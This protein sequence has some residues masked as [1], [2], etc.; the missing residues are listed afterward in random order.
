MVKSGLCRERERILRA[1]LQWGRGK[2]ASPGYGIVRDSVADTSSGLV[3][4]ATL[5]LNNWLRAVER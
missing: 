5:S 1:W 4:C 2:T 3:L